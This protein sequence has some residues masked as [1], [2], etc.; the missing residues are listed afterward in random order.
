MDPKK[1]K[2]VHSQI[3]RGPLRVKTGMNVNGFLRLESGP[4]ASARDLEALVAFGHP[5]GASRSLAE[6]SGQLP[7]L[8]KTR[9]HP[10]QFSTRS[11]SAV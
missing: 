10:C 9:S 3:T 5:P 1:F 8:R 11:D 7:T 6:P 2:K 4:S